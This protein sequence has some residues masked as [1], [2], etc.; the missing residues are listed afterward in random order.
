MP[1]ATGASSKTHKPPHQE[2]VE[3]RLLGPKVLSEKL[4]PASEAR[5]ETTMVTV[6][7]TLSGIVA[8]DTSV[9]RMRGSKELSAE[10]DPPLE[11][12]ATATVTI[13]TA[14][15]SAKATTTR[16]MWEVQTAELGKL[17]DCLRPLVL[18]ALP[19]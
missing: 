7:T 17:M 11:A 19:V 9:P 6:V 14:P 8:T 1:M 5:Q 3:P 2:N 13:T 16:P 4:R 15:P 10:V 18:A 12:R